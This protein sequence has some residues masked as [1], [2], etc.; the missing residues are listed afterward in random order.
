MPFNVFSDAP[1][2]SC[3]RAKQ[4]WHVQMVM[5]G[6]VKDR[7]S[8]LK[9]Q[10][11]LILM[12]I[13][14]MKLWLWISWMVHKSVRNT[15]TLIVSLRQ[16]NFFLKKRQYRYGFGE[17]WILLFMVFWVIGHAHRSFPSRCKVGYWSLDVNWHHSTHSL[18]HLHHTFN[19]VF[20]EMVIVRTF[21]CISLLISWS[22]FVG[23]SSR[24]SFPS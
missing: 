22:V 1:V 14:P 21:L 15:L 7:F 9:Y 11:L 23:N 16:N 4:A 10:A 17:E 24:L 5:V 19:C 2:L 12:Y 18:L 8:P 6:L 20:L 3:S 13:L